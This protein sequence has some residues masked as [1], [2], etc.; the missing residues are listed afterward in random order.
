MQITSGKKAAAVI[1]AA[2]LIGVL[3]YFGEGSRTKSYV[4]RLERNEPGMGDGI[5]EL[6]YSIEG[7]K[8]R[9]PFQLDVEER[10]WTKEEWEQHVDAAEAE[11]EKTFLADNES[12]EHVCG[13]VNLCEYTQDG[14]IEVEWSFTPD[15]KIDFEGN[16]IE[17]K[18]I[19]GEAVMVSAGLTCGEYK[20]V[21]EF[22]IKLYTR[23]KSEEEKRVSDILQYTKEQDKTKRQ[24]VLPDTAN[25]ERIIWY[26]KKSHTVLNFLLLGAAAAGGILWGERYEK[27][28]RRK[29]RDK[30]LLLDYPEIVSRLGL[31]LMAGMS[32]QQAWKK[33]VGVYEQKRRQYHGK[34]REGYEEMCITLHE[35]DDGVG[36]RK[37][38]ERFGERCALSQYRRLSSVLTQNMR[39]GMAGIGRILNQESENAFEQRKNAAHRIGEEAGTKL[40]FPM[41]LMLIVVM[42]ILVVPACMTM[43][44]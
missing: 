34:R 18:L 12:A 4:N 31:L 10:I 39:K 24:V 5:Q 19:E 33:M 21:Y 35:L 30:E 16:V 11:L 1:G 40:L 9:Y 28:K 25:G 17:E 42:V 37:A 22:P 32:L 23:E 38:F 20:A 36:E 13:R 2:F 26:P 29:L 44:I 14:I 8:E 7:E 27:E 3:V 6:F 43:H 41:M 15:N